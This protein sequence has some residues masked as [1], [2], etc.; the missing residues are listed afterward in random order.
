MAGRIFSAPDAYIVALGL[1]LSNSRPF[2]CSV[3]RDSAK[4]SLRPPYR[5]NHITPPILTSKPLE[6]SYHLQ[7]L[8]GC[9]T[10]ASTSS[11]SWCLMPR[12]DCD[13]LAAS[14]QK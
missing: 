1:L 11:K 2:F 8:L 13:E 6:P 4:Q 12:C 9:Q 3:S 14:L 5:G 10:C 7:T